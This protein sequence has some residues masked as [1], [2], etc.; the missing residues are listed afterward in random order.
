MFL[1][2]WLCLSF[3]LPLYAFD[4]TINADDN[5]ELVRPTLEKTDVPTGAAA[6]AYD[7]TTDESYYYRMSGHLLSNIDEDLDEPGWM[8]ESH[9]VDAIIGEDNRQV[10]AN[11][12]IAPYSAI[13]YIKVTYPSEE[14]Y[15]GTAVMISPNV[16]LTAAHCLFKN[17]EGGFPIS[18][19][20]TPAAYGSTM[21]S[22]FHAPYGT[23]TAR[24]VVISL[25]YFENRPAT[26]EDKRVA[27]WDWGVI[28]LNSNIGNYSGFLGLHYFDMYV[29]DLSVMIAGYPNDLNIANISKNQY[30]HNGLIYGDESSY[31][32]LSNNETYQTRYFSYIIDT[33]GGQSGSPILCYWEGAYKIIGIHS[34]RGNLDGNVCYTNEGFGLTS[35]V[36]QFLVTYK[37]NL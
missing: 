29:N 16:A 21:I 20:V 27:R 17:E 2:I 9:C 19:E 12:Q 31:T 14:E 5:A 8:P 24:E 25:T 7:L 4:G 26:N 32:T 33:T 28:R 23:A 1:G 36:F 13:A 37:N 30:K 10:V 35:E 22:N 34:G 11:T 15:V 3:A 6:L 18:I